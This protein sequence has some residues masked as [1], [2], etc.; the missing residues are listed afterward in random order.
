[1]ESIPVGMG[2]AH[3][4]P[5]AA[6]CQLYTLISLIT[7]LLSQQLECGVWRFVNIFQTVCS[8][9]TFFLLHCRAL[10]KVVT[11]VNRLCEAL[12][13]WFLTIAFPSQKLVTI[14]IIPLEVTRRIDCWFAHTL[15]GA[16]P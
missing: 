14:E 1:M 11:L 8:L 15:L 2:A 7:S 10:I 13:H 6:H 9:I 12:T 5:P 4:L 16:P 3:L